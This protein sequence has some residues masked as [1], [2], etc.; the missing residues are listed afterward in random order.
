[1]EITATITPETA[2]ANINVSEKMVYAH[3]QTR[4]LKMQITSPARIGKGPGGPQF[5]RALVVEGTL[6]KNRHRGDEPM[7]MHPMGERKKYPVIV[8]CPGSGF[9]GTEGANGGAMAFEFARRG[10]AVAVI[11]YRG[12]LLDDAH[13]PAYVQ[14][15]KE[16]VRFLRA[17][18]EKFSIDTDK[19]ILMG[20]SSGGNAAAMAA[21]TAGEK[22]FDIGENLEYSSEVSAVVCF[23]S[24]LDPQY[25]LQDKKDANYELRPGEKN[26]SF[27]AYEIYEDTFEDDPEGHLFECSVSNHIC[28]GKKLPAIACFNGDSDTLIP[29]MQGKRVCQKV[30]DCGGNAEFYV[31][32]GGGHGSG[33]PRNPQIQQPDF[34]GETFEAM[35]AF[36]KKYVL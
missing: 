6:V 34:C 7:P 5:K 1:M 8:Y 22:I 24:P 19:I 32:V 31:V 4:D 17:N 36:F 11:E 25:L 27:E 13:Y 21:M 15:A 14:D 33:A 35:E 2:I 18:A 26:Y 3:R 9:D 16:A 30:I 10:Y 23:C 12:S 20:T 29:L 28:E